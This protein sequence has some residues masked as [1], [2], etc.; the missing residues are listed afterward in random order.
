MIVS[1]KYIS[2]YITKEKT[3]IINNA[4]ETVTCRLIRISRVISGWCNSLGTLKKINIK[5]EHRKREI[6]KDDM[7]D[8][9]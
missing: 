5:K 3:I 7:I 1:H 4:L 6:K 8:T 2:Y 9:F